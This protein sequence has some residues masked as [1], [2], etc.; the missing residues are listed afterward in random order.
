MLAITIIANDGRIVTRFTSTN[1][2]FP[3]PILICAVSRLTIVVNVT[4]AAGRLRSAVP[5]H[6]AHRRA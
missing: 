6:M 3:G 2:I 1:A 4:L 5:C